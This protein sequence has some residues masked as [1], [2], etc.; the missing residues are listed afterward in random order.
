MQTSRT[1]SFFVKLG[2]IMNACAGTLDV[3]GTEFSTTV[4][5]FF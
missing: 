2:N 1:Y 3:R 5:P 4:D